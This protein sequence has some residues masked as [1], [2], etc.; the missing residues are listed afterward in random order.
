MLLV[1][2]S[3]IERNTVS[4]SSTGSFGINSNISVSIDFS[5]SSR[6]YLGRINFPP[7]IPPSI[8]S[9]VRIPASLKLP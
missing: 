7:I 5:N 8:L 6:S 4:G 1:A 3:Y 2:S 9:L